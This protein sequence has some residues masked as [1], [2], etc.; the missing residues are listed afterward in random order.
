MTRFFATVRRN[1]PVAEGYMLLSFE[2]PEKTQPPLPGQF[3][4]I[5]NT[6]STD[7]LLRRPFAISAF[8]SGAAEIVYQIR[9]KATHA[10]AARREGDGIDV[11][12]PLGNSFPAPREGALP[13]LLGGGIGFGPIY[14]FASHLQ[15]EGKHPVI[16]IGARTASSMPDLPYTGDYRFCT[17]DGTRGFHGTVVDLL[18][19]SEDIDPQSSVLYACGPEAMLAACAAFA[20]RAG[21][22][23]WV[24]MEQIMGCAVGACMGCAIRVK[25]EARYARVCTEGPV[26]DAEEI[27]WS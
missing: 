21:M 11:L 8:S 19:A 22:P 5:G 23:C 2:W 26:F 16:I 15:S 20:A 17:D 6:E 18:A 27:E 12:G 25:G 1:I 3:I 4:T 24:S 14:Y 7:P 9:G 13:V 10:I